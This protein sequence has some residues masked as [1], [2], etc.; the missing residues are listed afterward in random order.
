MCVPEHALDGSKLRRVPF[1]GVT[2]LCRPSIHSKND[3]VKLVLM[4]EKEVHGLHK[5]LRIAEDTIG[6]QQQERLVERFHQGEPIRMGEAETT[7]GSD[8]VMM[9]STMLHRVRR[10]VGD[11]IRLD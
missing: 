11:Q 10:T 2:D 8:V 1:L 9:P 4:L 7:L 6:F 5:L 3:E